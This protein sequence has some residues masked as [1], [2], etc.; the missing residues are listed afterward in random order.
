M[1]L[2]PQCSYWHLSSQFYCNFCFFLLFQPIKFWEVHLVKMILHKFKMY[3]SKH[4]RQREK[5]PKPTNYAFF[6]WVANVLPQLHKHL[7]W[8][9]HI[10]CTSSSH[11]WGHFMYWADTNIWYENITHKKRKTCMGR[12]IKPSKARQL[13]TCRQELKI[14]MHIQLFTLY[15]L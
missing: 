7:K 3:C 12:K 1:Q 11:R 14:T 8:V 2:G 6:S 5:I 9:M 15:F 13:Q 4:L 10:S